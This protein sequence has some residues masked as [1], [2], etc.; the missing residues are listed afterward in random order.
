MIEETIIRR[1]IKALGVSCPHDSTCE[2]YSKCAR[3]TAEAVVAAV[4]PL[5]ESETL[6]KVRGTR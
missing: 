6:R 3:D 1:A 2:D 5:I 4:R